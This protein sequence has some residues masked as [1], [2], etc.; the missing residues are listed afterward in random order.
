MSSPPVIGIVGGIGAGKSM[1]AE[2]L[3][4]L[5]CFVADADRYAHEALKDP[6]VVEQ[7]REHW[8]GDV[9]GEDGTPD[10]AAIGA[11]V[12]VDDGERAWLERIL[13]PLVCQ[14]RNVEFAS[15]PK[16][17]PALV[18]DAPLLIEAGLDKDCDYLVFVEAPR[19]E[20]LDRVARNRG[21][22]E[23]ELERRENAQDNLARKRLN[24]DFI[25]DNDGDLSTLR[26]RVEE[27]LASIRP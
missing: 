16:D 12:F 9:I 6:G 8:G 1:V 10:R 7:L 21:W 23:Q 5:G 14:R 25:I 11:I 2:I 19:S 26:A 18:I 22:N 4:S 13:H 17:V 20:R 24:S 3:A 15:A 27:F